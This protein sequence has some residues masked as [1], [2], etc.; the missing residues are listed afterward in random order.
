MPQTQL[1]IALA[2][3]PAS[4]RRLRRPRLQR[5]PL[6]IERQYAAEIRKV[7]DAVIARVNS[8]ILPQLGRWQRDAGIRTDQVG[9][10]IDELEV[11]FDTIRREFERQDGEFRQVAETVSRETSSFNRV[12]VGRQISGVVGS[13]VLPLSDDTDTIRGFVNSN[14]QAIKSVP[15]QYL[16][17][18]ERIIS[19]GFR[20]GRRAESL[21]GEIAER[22]KVTRNRARFIARD[23]ISTLNAQLT[24]RR[25]TSLGVEQYIWRTSLDERVRPT[26]ANLEGTTHSWDDPPTVGSRRVHPGEDYNCRCT[27]EPVID[28]I[29]PEET[30]P[31]DV[32]APITPRRPRAP[33]RRTRAPRQAAAAAVE[34][35]RR[36]RQQ[37]IRDIPTTAEPTVARMPRTGEERRLNADQVLRMEVSR[38][39]DQSPATRAVATRRQR[40][41]RLLW[42]WL[43]GAKRKT[44]IEMKEAAVQAFSLRGAVYNPRNFR[45]DPRDVAQS[46]QDLQA[47]YSQTQA[48]LAAQG[49]RN[50]TVYRGV[51]EAQN[52]RGAVESWT[53]SRATAEKFAGPQGKVLT[54]TVPAERILA[55]QG[56]PQ[57]LDGV[58]GNQNEVIV[59]Y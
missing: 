28:G 2:M 13:S 16:D 14:V 25:Q 50:V 21:A 40:T 51:K 42:N 22:G 47:L 11:S 48:A 26:H 18:V 31:E 32:P 35:P 36:Q 49:R 53:T 19:E 59:L 45:P 8:Q 30:G 24:Q 23:Q 7:A 12:Q 56:G 29:E 9:D 58:F 38:V 10:W 1:D 57:W 43:H 6:N 20:S 52:E 55:I 39:L 15:N 4:K 41:D 3:R 46:S 33:A 5:N 27:P 44:S 54:E 37:R 17:Q 34:D